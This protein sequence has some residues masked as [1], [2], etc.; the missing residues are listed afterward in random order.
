MVGWSGYQPS[1]IAAL[2]WT[3]TR[4]EKRKNNACRASL[5]SSRMQHSTNE[6]GSSAVRACSHTEIRVYSLFSQQK[7]YGLNVFTRMWLRCAYAYTHRHTHR[8]THLTHRYTTLLHAG[9]GLFMCSFIC[10][11]SSFFV[12]SFVVIHLLWCARCFVCATTTTTTMM[13][14]SFLA[15]R[16]HIYTINIDT[17]CRSHAYAFRHANQRTNMDI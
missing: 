14:V 16:M 11:I 17:I 3:L 13:M 7:E 6:H 9:D 8:H 12:T 15:F 4:V 2:A 1:H 10:W 5:W